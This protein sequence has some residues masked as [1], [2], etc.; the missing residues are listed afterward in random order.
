MQ[1]LG[2]SH[3]GVYIKL[4]FDEAANAYGS[5]GGLPGLA[6]SVGYN[7]LE[8]GSNGFGTDEIIND[9]LQKKQ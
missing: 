9:Q 4:T 3:P 8:Y 5:F 6:V 1:K 7:A 2:G